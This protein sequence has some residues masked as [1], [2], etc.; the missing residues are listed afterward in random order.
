MKGMSRT[1]TVCNSNLDLRNV[2]WRGKTQNQTIIY[3]HIVYDILKWFEK[4]MNAWMDLGF[5]LK[6]L[7]CFLTAFCSLMSLQFSLDSSSCWALLASRLSLS[8]MSTFIWASRTLVRQN[9]KML[10]LPMLIWQIQALVKVCYWL[11]DKAIIKT[12]K[13]S[14]WHGCKCTIWFGSSN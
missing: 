7:L 13:K 10:H 12:K 1:E 14:H 2:N 3:N 6:G 4:T 9:H 11:F 5:F 8:A